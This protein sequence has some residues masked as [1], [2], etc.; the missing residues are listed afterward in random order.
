MGSRKGISCVFG[1]RQDFSRKCCSGW[2]SKGVA[3][4]SRQGHGRKGTRK[5]HQEMVRNSV[6]LAIALVWEAEQGPPDIPALTPCALSRGCLAG[7]IKLRTL[8][9]GDHSGLSGWVYYNHKGHYKREAGR[10]ERQCK[11]DSR[12]Q[13]RARGH[14]AGSEAVEGVGP[15]L[16]PPC[17]PGH[18]QPL[19]VAIQRKCHLSWEGKQPALS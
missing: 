17:L 15:S 2:N 16:K 19:E 4:S 6:S 9:W 3:T 1:C 18:L 11:H 12:E 10:S 14:A 5:R 13:K 7:V 8:R